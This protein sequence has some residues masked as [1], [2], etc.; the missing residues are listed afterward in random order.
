MRRPKRRTA[1]IVTAAVAVVLL[2]AGLPLFQPW[3]AFTN[4]VVD[5]A[6]PEAAPPTSTPPVSVT[7]SIPPSSTTAPTVSAARPATLARGTLISHEHD[8]RGSVAIL[9]LADGSRVLRLEGLDTSD[10]PDLEV[11]LSDAQVVPGR[12]GWHLFDDGRYHDLG[13]LK[14]NKGNQNY[15]IPA[16]LDL[17][18]YRSVTIWCDRFNV[19]F[20][21]ATLATA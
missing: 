11:W 9:R 4:T 20:G 1:V 16:A 18:D 14:G 8:T 15:P 6:L 13:D 19:S 10:G 12:A 21:A 5:E 17:A 3:R 2:G 7:P